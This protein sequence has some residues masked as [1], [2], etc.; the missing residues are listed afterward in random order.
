MVWHGMVWWGGSTLHCA[1]CD[2]PAPWRR[3]WTNPVSVYRSVVSLFLD[4]ACCCCAAQCRKSNKER[5]VAVSAVTQGA[6]DSSCDRR[7]AKAQGIVSGRGEVP[8]SISL[9]LLKCETFTIHLR[10]GTES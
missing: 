4:G 7:R 3:A 10:H 8:C 2:K 5:C 1:F 6:T 9:T